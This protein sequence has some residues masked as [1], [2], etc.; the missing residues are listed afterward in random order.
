MA[1]D[2]GPMDTD[3]EPSRVPTHVDHESTLIDEIQ[4]AVSGQTATFCCGG[5][6]PIIVADSDEAKEHR[7]DDVAGVIVSPA[8][9]LRWDLSSGTYAL[10]SYFLFLSSHSLSIVSSI[11]QGLSY[12]P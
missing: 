2:S 1:S 7:F 9:V 10:I 8:V 11:A 12:N 4:S 5:S 6:V 3:N